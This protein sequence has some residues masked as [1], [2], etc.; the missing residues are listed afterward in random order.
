MRDLPDL[1]PAE[2]EVMKVLWRKGRAT[3]KEVQKALGGKPKRAYTTVATLLSRLRQR[4]YVEA[5][6][7]NFA[8]VFRP[9]VQRNLVAR[10]KLDDLVKRVLAGS[11]APLATYIAENRQLTAEQIAALE[12]IV[13]EETESRKPNARG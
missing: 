7:R 10:R 5:E 1:P 4:G 3:V 6:E 11:V 12:K 9:L 13:Q 2:L 8:Y